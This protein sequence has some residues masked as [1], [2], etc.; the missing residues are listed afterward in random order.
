MKRIIAL[1]FGINLLLN[2]NSFAQ[3]DWKEYVYD[4][5]NFKIDFYESPIYSSD[6][7]IFSNKEHVAHFWEVNVQDSLHENVYYQLCV[8]SY[9]SDF[10]HSDSL[11]S[12]VEGF[13]NSTQNSMFEDETYTLMTSLL[14]EKHGFPGKAFKWKS[15]SSNVFIEY[16]VFLVENYLFQ[17]SVVTND[18]KGHNSKIGKYFDS[19]EIQNISKGKFSLS[20]NTFERR[21]EIVF[22]A[23]PSKE[24]RIVDSEYGRLEIDIQVLETIQPSDNMVYVALETKYPSSVINQD[25][26]YQLNSYYKKSID[27][28]VNTVSGELISITDIFYKG[29]L[30]KEY[31]CYY[32]N[33]EALMVY[34]IFY[35]DN[36]V[37]TFGVI[38]LPNKD[39]N[40][41]M[42]KFFKSFKVNN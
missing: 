30:G 18:G 17:L 19:F 28:S 2:I 5:H 22:P 3:A 27:N 4:S 9:P 7:S 1:A 11:Q 42:E 39:S 20:E 33:G 37:Y 41:A 6:T 25:D 29:R 8:E 36:R 23:A 10:I 21:M 24:N 26:T 34:Q 32:S 31:K 16:Q 15:N 38:T 13:I 14:L 40:K 12:V 35:I